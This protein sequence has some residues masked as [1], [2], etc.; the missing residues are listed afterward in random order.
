MAKT[1]KD[2]VAGAFIRSL[3]AF[4]EDKPIPV[5]IGFSH[6]LPVDEIKTLLNKQINP[7]PS[8]AIIQI[9]NRTNIEHRAEE[10]EEIARFGEYIYYYYS[11]TTLEVLLRTFTISEEDSE[12]VLDEVSHFISGNRLIAVPGEEP[13]FEPDYLV[14][15]FTYA[16]YEEDQ[17]TSYNI[18]NINYMAEDNEGD[19]FQNVI[20][21]DVNIKRMLAVRYPGIDEV[22][23]QAGSEETYGTWPT[24][25]IELT[26]DSGSSYIVSGSGDGGADIHFEPL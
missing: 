24:F 12:W 2:I 7:I 20:S 19:L 9:G 10:Y 4:T 26:D 11:T 13:S 21:F 5:P 8:C 23:Y 6:L 16:Y 22:I 1:L 14:H 3:M 18:E 25:S 15:T 17:Y